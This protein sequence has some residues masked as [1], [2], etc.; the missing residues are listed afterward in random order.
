MMTFAK[1]ELTANGEDEALR[2]CDQPVRAR[3]FMKNL[4]QQ[5]FERVKIF[6]RG[7]RIEWMLAKGYHDWFMGEIKAGRTI[8]PGLGVPG[9]ERATQ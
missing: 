3:N 7:D 1:G 2:Q 5:N 8:W 4:A 6:W 9:P